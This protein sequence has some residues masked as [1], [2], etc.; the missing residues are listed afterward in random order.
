LRSQSPVTDRVRQSWNR[1]TLPMTATGAFRLRAHDAIRYVFLRQ[2]ML[3]HEWGHTVPQRRIE[4]VTP[5]SAAATLGDERS[6]TFGIE[7]PSNSAR[8]AGIATI[9]RNFNPKHAHRAR[10]LTVFVA[11]EHRGKGYGEKLVVAALDHARCWPGV[12]VIDLFV[13]DD[14]QSAQR[15]YKR[16]GFVE[17]NHNHE[18]PPVTE[19]HMMLSFDGHTTP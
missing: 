15:L 14:A 6:A 5:S 8:L 17:W 2:Q 11:E 12:K 1:Y 10:L 7:A 16:L 19:V 3:I 18:Q 9:V 4:T 13:N